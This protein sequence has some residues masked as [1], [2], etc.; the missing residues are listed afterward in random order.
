MLV[1]ENHQDSR[2]NGVLEYSELGI[3]MMYPQTTFCYVLCIAMDFVLALQHC[4]SGK[5]MEVC[6]DG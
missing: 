1:Q 6:L 2:A 5:C 3:I 4:C